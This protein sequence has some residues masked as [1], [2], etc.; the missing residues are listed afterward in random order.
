MNIVILGPQGSG[1]GTQ[2]KLLADK[3][4]FF[5][6]ESGRMLREVAEKDERI[7]RMLTRGE[8]VPD[9]ETL[10]YMEGYLAKNNLS[11]SGVIFDGYPRN[12][13]QY[14]LLRRWL[15]SRKS[16][17]D[18]VIYL[19]ID[20]STSIKRLSARRTCV[21]C[22]RIYNLITNPPPS[23]DSCECGGDLIQREDDK[24]E[25]IRKRLAIF[26]KDTMPI[27]DQAESD[28]LLIKIDGER[29]IEV[30]FKDILEKLRKQNG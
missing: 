13:N 18:K 17:L 8:I 24:P 16:T 12:I 1:K 20:E 3:L 14:K 4:G 26:K 2:A 11:A 22:G 5:H 27:L 23:S 9:Q 25:V 29:S 28:G 30:I 21:K 15:V 19:A 7:K 6:M 10:N